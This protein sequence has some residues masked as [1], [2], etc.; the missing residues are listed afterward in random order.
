[1]MNKGD[2][3][4]AVK[5]LEPYAAKFSKNDVVLANLGLCYLNQQRLDDAIRVLNQT[6]ALNNEN[7]NA[8]YFLGLAYF[9]KQEFTNAASILTNVVKANPYFAPPY[10]VLSQCMMRL[11]DQQSAMTYSSIYRQLSGGK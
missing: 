1:M 7:A 4:D 11:G 5:V 10:N 9:Y 2:Y 3:A 6:I 8:G